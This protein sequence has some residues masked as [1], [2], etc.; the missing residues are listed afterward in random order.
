MF[1]YARAVVRG[2]RRQAS[3]LARS[4]PF[5]GRALLPLAEAYRAMKGEPPHHRHPAA[6][7]LQVVEQPTNPDP[8]TRSDL[9]DELVLVAACLRSRRIDGFV[10]DEEWVRR[11]D[12]GIAATM[13]L[14]L[15]AS[16]LCKGIRSE[17]I[18]EHVAEFRRLY[19]GAPITQNNYGM[20]FPGGLALFVISRCLNP[21]IIVESGVYRGLSSYL[22]AKAAPTARIAAFDPRLNEVQYRTPRVA[23][24]PCDWM[25]IE[26]ACEGD[27]L[28]FF[29]DHQS[30]ARRVIE[31]HGRGFR[32]LIFDDSWPLETIMG[33]GY[34]PM[35]SIDMVMGKIAIG[36]R[37]T[38]VEG[39]KLCTYVHTAAMC[40]LCTKARALIKSAYDVPGLYRETGIAPSSALKVVELI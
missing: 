12:A 15:E 3:R 36:E 31:A 30:Q 22:L 28:A 7:S 29:D 2:F 37:L 25:Q 39:N 32:H 19:A 1:R 10:V 34:P 24:H 8:I 11:Q 17:T 23:Y 38:W 20:N 18:A 33:C 35:P 14:F 40:E 21:K 13:S 5:W 9:P 6:P 16:G 26:I 27:G 4:S